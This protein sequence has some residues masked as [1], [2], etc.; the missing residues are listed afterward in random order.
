MVD[1]TFAI[2][3]ELVRAAAC[4][5]DPEYTKS[6]SDDV[7]KYK[8]PAASEDPSE[9]VDGFELAAPIYTSEK[10]VT[11]A[12]LVAVVDT[13]LLMPATVVILAEIPA[14]VALLFVPLI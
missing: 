8:S 5:A 1:A 7:L 10:L 6:A 9:R 3:S 2:K 14:R 11:A 12:T 4:Q 13:A